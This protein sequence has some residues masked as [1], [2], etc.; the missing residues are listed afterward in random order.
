MNLIKKVTLVALF[1]L[2]A[3]AASWSQAKI[4]EAFWTAPIAFTASYGGYP[5]DL[6]P[7]LLFRKAKFKTTEQMDGTLL[8][9]RLEGYTLKGNIV[10]FSL[11]I[12]S[13]HD[14]Q[15]KISVAIQYSQATKQNAIFSVAVKNLNSGKSTEVSFDGS[16]ES[17]GTTTG[18]FLELVSMLYD[19]DELNSLMP[20]YDGSENDN[21]SQQ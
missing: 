2:L 15:T 14:I 18:I 4:P 20:N 11:S 16:P 10:T 17:V 21:P 5:A 1:T 9:G 13:K 8:T 3:S 19:S 7:D 6:T 12:M